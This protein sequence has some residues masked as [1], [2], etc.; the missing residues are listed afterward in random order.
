MRPFDHVAARGAFL[1]ALSL[2]A[3]ARPDPVV[4]D[5][6]RT[7]SAGIR[8]VSSGATDKDLTWTFEP[9]GTMSDSAGEPWLFTG[10]HPRR[11]M[12]DRGGRTYVLTDDPSV[13]RF[14]REGRYDRTIGR[15]GGGPGEMQFPMSIGSQG[16][17]IVVHDVMKGTL[18]RWGPNLDPIADR[19]LDGALTGAESIAFR[20]GGFWAVME[21]YSD[22]II[23]TSLVSDT[24]PVTALHSVSRSAGGQANLGCVR[25]NGMPPLFSPTLTWSVVGPRIIVNASADYEIWMHEGARPMA[26]VRRRV[27]SRAPTIEDV[28]ELHPGGMKVGFV[29]GAPECIAS[30][31]KAVEQF[32]LAA[33]MPAMHDIKLFSDGTIW[34]QR[35]PRSGENQVMDLFSADGA[36]AGTVRG[37][38]MPVGMFPS[39]DLL[40]PQ[41]DADTGGNVL[42]RMRVTK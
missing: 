40:V 23:T 31:E 14:G 33:R 13:V 9:V 20:S 10:T 11:V 2:A 39:G 19:R 21:S 42:V 8:I 5:V 25:L 18:V 35:T 29:S 7:D 1:I 15:R 3:C 38:Q 37:M 36:Y 16:D 6:T 24:M 34:V 41:E 26:S 32:G 4:S 22:T 12:I 27:P 17:S 28:R 30:A